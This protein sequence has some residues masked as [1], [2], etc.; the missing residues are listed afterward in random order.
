MGGDDMKSKVVAARE[1]Q[2]G[3]DAGAYPLGKLWQLRRPSP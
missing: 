3:A 1:A 2:N